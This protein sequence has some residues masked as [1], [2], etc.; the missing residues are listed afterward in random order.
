MP[1]KIPTTSQ[2]LPSDKSVETFLKVP[3]TNQRTI[4]RA[5]S[6]RYEYGGLRGSVAPE[7]YWLAGIEQKLTSKA[8][9]MSPIGR[10]KLLVGIKSS[11]TPALEKLA[12]G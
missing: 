12:V 1:L 9:S 11:I 3:P 6:M 8:N 4:L 7:K 5:L 2:T 10:Y